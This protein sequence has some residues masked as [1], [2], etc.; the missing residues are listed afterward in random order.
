MN[1]QITNYICLLVFINLSYGSVVKLTLTLKFSKIVPWTL[2]TILSI[3]IYSIDLTPGTY[4]ACFM[5]FQ[6][7]C[8]LLK[9]HVPLATN[10][11]HFIVK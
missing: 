8:H 10:H 11:S 6:T 7:W 9:K 3:Y 5:V 4:I 2:L 1:V